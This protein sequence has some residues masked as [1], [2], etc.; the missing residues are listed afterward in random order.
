MQSGNAGQQLMRL[1]CRW[2][3]AL[4]LALCLL[5][6]ADSGKAES[7]P[8]HYR[9]AMLAI[10]DGRVNDAEAALAILI[11]DEPRHAGA[12]LDLAMLYC[13]AGRTDDA[14]HLF[15]E[16]ER[17]FAPPPPI[18]EVI[19]RQRTLGCKGRELRNQATLRIGRGSESNV[20]QGA[21]NPNFTLGSGSSQI[22]LVLLPE[23][24]PR[25]DAFTNLNLELVRD[26]SGSGATGVF[27]LQSRAYD[28]MSRY[29]TSSLF[30]GL[31]QPWR[32]AGWGWRLAGLSGLMTLGSHVYLKQSQ[33]QFE[34]TPPFNLP[35]GWQLSFAGGW[36]Y[37][38]YPTLNG[39]DAQLREARS[40]LSYRG[41]ESWW[42]AS[43]G[44]VEDKQVGRRPGGD[45]SGTF[46]GAQG[47]MLL[48]DRV[49]GEISVQKQRWQG[50]EVYFPGLIDVRRSQDTRSIRAALTYSLA[51]QQAIQ[52]EYK[53]IRNQENVSLFDYRNRVLLLNWQ[54]QPAR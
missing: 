48:G 28:Q 24:R 32:W 8:D 22:D 34:T 45:R 7:S 26:L 25:G 40:S 27:Q 51:D 19:A 12:W 46:A 5:G 23:Y 49:M 4:P 35:A 52:L 39:F 50:A 53:D 18:L 17:R 36:S 29:N 33:L 21:R 1:F 9:D 30:V 2:L 47:R 10:T 6:H 15:A 31:E 44:A 42:Q 3:C 41:E 14:E 37:L 13:A 20:N 54:W 43:V 16:I 38:A 11:R